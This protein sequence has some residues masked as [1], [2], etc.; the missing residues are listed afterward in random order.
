MRGRRRLRRLWQW[1]LD[2][3]GCMTDKRPDSSSSRPAPISIAVDKRIEQRRHE[4]DK[5]QEALAFEAHVDGTHISA[6]ER[7]IANPSVQTLADLA[8]VLRTS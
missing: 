1:R 3:L 8:P 4:V 7:G 2:I 6:I 5:F